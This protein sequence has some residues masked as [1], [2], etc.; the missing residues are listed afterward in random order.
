MSVP[1]TAGVNNEFV[2][3][4]GGF[5]EVGQ[6]YAWKGSFLWFTSVSE[7]SKAQGYQQQINLNAGAI[8]TSLGEDFFKSFQQYKIT[9]GTCTLYDVV[10][11]QA[12][13]ASTAYIVMAPYP[14][15][16]A[17][18]AASENNIR[19]AALPGAQWKV[20]NLPASRDRSQTKEFNGIG[21]D[22][23]L[24]IHLDQPMYFFEAFDASNSL[25][26]NTRRCDPLVTQSHHGTNATKWYGWLM[27]CHQYVT[28]AT[29]PSPL[30]FKYCI[31]YH[32][33]MTGFKPIVG[34]LERQLHV[35][36][37]ESI[38]VGNNRATI[39]N[40]TSDSAEC[41]RNGERQS[42]THTSGTKRKRSEKS[43][44]RSIIPRQTSTQ[45]RS[46]ESGISE[47]ELDS[48]SKNNVRRN[49]R[50]RSL[51]PVNAIPTW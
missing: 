20:F 29:Y 10:G 5:Q 7:A 38:Y 27:D 40:G 31:K 37:I 33:E 35:N 9:G 24:T 51:S 47:E 13:E 6:E 15:P 14:W 17:Q 43:P 23:M 49:Q 30:T 25:T 44:S 46:D 8:R 34:T 22:Q 16:I 36:D 39:T 2:D 19:T 4:Q 28:T 12:T 21:N 50:G 26:G 32:V 42:E 45:R 18:N 41:D 1:T 3:I 11:P 48:T